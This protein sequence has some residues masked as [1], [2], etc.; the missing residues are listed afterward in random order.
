MHTFVHAF[1][2]L[3]LVSGKIGWQGLEIR[4]EQVTFALVCLSI[5]RDDFLLECDR[6]LIVSVTLD[7]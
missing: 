4:A 5:A 7:I 6:V 3:A 1:V 2:A